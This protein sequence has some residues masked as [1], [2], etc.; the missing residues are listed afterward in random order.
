VG[1]GSRRWSGGERGTARHE[2][3]GGASPPSR[4]VCCGVPRGGNRG[5]VIQYSFSLRQ[6]NE[7]FPFKCML[8]AAVQ[9]RCK[10]SRTKKK[11]SLRSIL[12]FV[13]MNI[14]STKTCL[15][16]SVFAKDNMGR[17][18]YYNTPF[19]MKCINLFDRPPPRVAP[20]SGARG[21][22]SRHSPLL[23]PSAAA[24]GLRRG[25]SGPRCRRWRGRCSRAAPVED[26]HVG[27]AV[28]LRRQEAGAAAPGRAGGGRSSG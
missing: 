24:V 10:N 27:A 8:L 3:L 6:G 19:V 26:R 1:W 15:D 22:P 11:Y 2:R 28:D 13:N 25:G 5:T 23:L 18:K 21:N 14:S 9:H 16:I 20:P 17:R 7:F 4:L 12:S